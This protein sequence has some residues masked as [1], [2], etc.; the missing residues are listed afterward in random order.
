MSGPFVLHHTPVRAD[1]ASP[2]AWLLVLHGIYGSGGNWRT[3][4]RKLVAER[5]DWGALLVDLRMHGR[6]QNAPPP[7]TVDAAAADIS[8]LADLCARD[9]MPVRAILGHSFGGKVA[10]RYRA[11]AASSL[12]Q[13]WVID[14]SPS[15]RPG[16]LDEPD[17]TVVQVL[18]ILT[19]LPTIFASRQE[20]V[21]AIVARG[22]AAGVG[23]WLAM[24]LRR[25]A[26]GVYESRLELPAIRALLTDYYRSDLWPALT[27]G[28]GAVHVVVAGRSSAIGAADRQ[29]LAD[30]AKHEPTVA[31][32]VIA[33]SGHWVHVE[34]LP[35]LL[36]TVAG[37]LPKFT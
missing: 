7:H 22:I 28:P 15:A 8:A 30:T 27:T 33:D 18:R 35:A 31:T 24:N 19:E 11:L 32:S 16:A 13:T 29:R 3:F 10:L 12:A 26:D 36:A 6:S 25:C 21:D 9:E 2:G 34:A 20:F 1:G 4:A 37:G 14:A 5:P 17:N 23:Q